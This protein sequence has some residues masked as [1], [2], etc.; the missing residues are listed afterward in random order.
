MVTHGGPTLDQCELLC[1]FCW[2]V[3]LSVVGR[4]DCGGHLLRCAMYE[5][6]SDTTDYKERSNETESV[7]RLVC[8][9]EYTSVIEKLHPG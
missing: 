5:V 7:I 1:S 3:S 9:I 6:L 2:K 8:I 4:R